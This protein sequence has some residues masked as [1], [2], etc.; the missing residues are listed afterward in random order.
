MGMGV[1]FSLR[2]PPQRCRLQWNN[3]FLLATVLA[4]SRRTAMS[5]DNSAGAP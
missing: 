3:L 1:Q 5:G 2:R 4:Y